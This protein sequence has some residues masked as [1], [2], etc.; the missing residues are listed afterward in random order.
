MPFNRM[1]LNGTIANWNHRKQHERNSFSLLTS[2]QCRLGGQWQ[3]AQGHMESSVMFRATLIHPRPS[4]RL[5]LPLYDL[6]I[7]RELPGS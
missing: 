4:E 7:T 6:G 3:P 2:Q 1:P 5:C